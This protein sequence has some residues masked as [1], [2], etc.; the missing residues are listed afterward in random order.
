MLLGV[1]LGVAFGVEVRPVLGAA[2]EIKGKL[3]MK[4]SFLCKKTIQHEITEISHK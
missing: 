2:R 1:I 4:L 3:T